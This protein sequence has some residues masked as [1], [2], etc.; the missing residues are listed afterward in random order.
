[1]TATGRNVQL[2]AT[3]TESP[4]FSGPVRSQSGLFLVLW[5]GLLNTTSNKQLSGFIK[6]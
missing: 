6:D 3:A 5:T 2:A 1:M 4:V